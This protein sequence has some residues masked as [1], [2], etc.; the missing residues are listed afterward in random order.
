MA[1][2]FVAYNR[3]LDIVFMNRAMADASRERHGELLG[4]NHW[5][6]WPDMRGTVVE[7]SFGRA[8]ETGLPRHFEYHYPRSD[9]WVEVDVF[10]SGDYLHVYFR[11]VT[12]AKRAEGERERRE[13]ELRAMVDGFPQI[14]WAA[15][16]DRAPT[17]L[18]RRWYAYTGTSP[19]DPYDAAKTVHPEDMGLLA[20]LGERSA[21][22]GQAL[23]AEARLRRSDGTYRWHLIRMEPYRDGNGEVV[24]WFGTSADVHELRSTR[25]ELRRLLD[26]MTDGL[27]GLDPEWRIVRL[28]P[29][30][31]RHFGIAERDVFGKSV[32]DVFPAAKGS[33][34][35][36]QYRLAVEEGRPVSFETPSMVAGR[37]VE[38]RA[39]PHDGGLLVSFSDITDRRQAE[40]T[41]RATADAVPAM[42]S[43]VGPDYR[44]RFV[45]GAYENLFGRP[46]EQ[47]VGCPVR[48]MMGDAA[49]EVARPTLERAMAGEETSFEKWLP[50][51]AGRR[52]MRA[53]YKPRLGFGG[54]VEGV[55]VLVMDETERR[56]AAERVAAQAELLE[57]A[58]DAIVVYGLDGTITFWNQSAERKYGWSKEEAADRNVHELLQTEGDVSVKEILSQLLASGGWEGELVHVRRDGSRITVSSKWALRRDEAGEPREILAINRDVT[59]Q[60]AAETALAERE[61]RLRLV[62]NLLPVCVSYIGADERYRFVN[63]TYERWFGVGVHEVVGK[64][65]REM[66]GDIVYETRREGIARVLR[67][68]AITFEGPTHLADGTKL[69]TE[70]TYVPDV[71]GD[72][73]QGFVAMVRDLTD[74]MES[75]RAVRESEVRYRTLAESVPV[76]VWTAAADGAVNFVNGRWRAYHGINDEQ[77][78]GSDWIDVVYPADR[79]LVMTEWTRC[80]REQTPYVLQYRLRRYDG[81]YRWHLCVAHPEVV[82]GAIRGW[83]GGIVDV[84]EQRTREVVLSLLVEIADRTRDLRDP[85]ETVGQTISL[86]GR[87]LGVSRTAY[88]EV[89][90]DEDGFEV[91]S[92]YSEAPAP[93]LGRFR[94]SDFGASIHAQQ[95]R[96]NATAVSD[97]R[98]ASETAG[99]ADA[100]ESILVRSFICIPLVKRG[101]LIAMVS[102]QHH[103]PRNWTEEE[104]ELVRAVADRCWSEIE[105]ARAERALAEANEELEER[106]QQR[107]SDLLSANERL[108]GFTYHVSHDLRGPLRAIVSTSRIIQED[109]GS[110]LPREVNQLLVRQAEA[111]NRMGQ[112]V[113]DLLK[114]SRLSRQEMVL[115]RV[116][117]TELARDAAAEALST[118]PYTQVNVEVE[119]G[120]EADADPRLLRLALLN[121]VENAIKYS[122]DGG[123]VRVGR[124]HEA[125]FVSDQGIGIEPQYLERIFEPFQRLHRDEEF[126]GTGIGLANVR[127]V[128]E[129][130]GGRVWAES[131]RGVGSTFW[132]EL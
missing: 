78:Y 29:R 129:R 126:R 49:F 101:R 5:D 75:E 54:R 12:A 69:P 92:Q 81:E 83:I 99:M 84:H 119:D 97:V 13:A 127:Q 24:G 46:R 36:R 132:F 80:L 8:L 74:R 112:L 27:I 114:L 32:W 39:F 34:F 59:A 89:D 106:V 122:P 70:I 44:Y 45:N 124:R 56:L 121:L 42:I 60:K 21:S 90:Q 38:V 47:I 113:D 2:M 115:Q 31:E 79:S 40:E 15:G 6:V 85:S 71:Q 16:R 125:F 30:A 109:F 58:H 107:T 66:L 111:A 130:H 105:R 117:L 1:D 64:S 100:F 76:M 94:L 98:A 96:G 104:I 61:Q 3:Q 131:E 67:G 14:A 23:E 73:V 72:E 63:A 17:Y 86:L 116:D 25:D 62:S 41:L 48:E 18:N 103:E 33:V 118:H 95:K 108:Q 52:F 51:E 91:V 93:T 9:V 55:H 10:P 20:E 87:H 35:E 11:D 22:A 19:E 82:E 65:I 128:L 4:R 68:E 28:N 123:K 43:Y 53:M 26:S 88:A 110:E 50:L 7:E 102:V 120:L 57:L 77:A 37:W